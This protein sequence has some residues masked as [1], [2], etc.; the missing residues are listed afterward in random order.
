[1]GNKCSEECADDQQCC[2][3]KTDSGTCTHECAT[4]LD[5]N[6]KSGSCPNAVNADWLKINKIYCYLA[7]KQGLVEE[8]ECRHDGDCEGNRKCCSPVIADD[9]PTHAKCRRVC[10]TPVGDDEEDEEMTEM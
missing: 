8:S 3:K 9:D 1:M 10:S 7:K 5:V 2:A 6:P 4:K